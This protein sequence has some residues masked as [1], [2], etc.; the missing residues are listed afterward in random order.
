MT[1]DDL[2]ARIAGVSALADPVRRSLYQFV[3][4]QPGAV[5]RDQ[6]AA[7]LDLPRHTAKFHLDRLV[8]EGLLVPEFRRLSGRRGPGAGR[9]AK[10][11]RRSERQLAVS[12]PERR[13]DVAGHLLAAAIERAADDG[14]PVRTAVGESAAEE[15]RR[16][17]AS[18][19]G[20][21]PQLSGPL[22]EAAAVLAE[23]GYEPRVDGDVAV[24]ANC[25]FS[26]LAREHTAL[27]CGMNHDLIGAFLAER[28][29]SSI[30]AR[31]D[32]ADGRCCVTLISRQ[33]PQKVR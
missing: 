15:G 33:V 13:Y 26:D 12:L 16:I 22:E 18:S 8:E 6:A 30:E 17:A 14:T 11:Y 23:H 3:V 19:S 10:L 25:P 7:E 1:A 27:V 32:P 31:L 2:D 5:S 20:P 24:L 29:Y 4:R 28:G 9:P 21:G